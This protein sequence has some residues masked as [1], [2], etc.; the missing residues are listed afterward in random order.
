[1]L[2]FPMGSEGVRCITGRVFHGQR[3][4][5]IVLRSLP[6]QRAIDPRRLRF[7]DI[8]VNEAAVRVV[9]APR[10]SESFAKRPDIFVPDTVDL[11]VESPAEIVIRMGCVLGRSVGAIAA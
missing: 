3:L 10:V 11:E 7:S 9:A 8:E 4:R 6:R 2:H 5:G 1:M